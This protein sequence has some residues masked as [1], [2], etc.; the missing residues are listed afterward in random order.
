MPISMNI[1][2]RAFR[3]N[4]DDDLFIMQMKRLVDTY[5]FFSL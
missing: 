5:R 1:E 4:D 3:F 2:H